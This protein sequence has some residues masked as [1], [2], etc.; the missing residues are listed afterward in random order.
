MFC[1]RYVEEEEYENN[2]QYEKYLVKKYIKPLVDIFEVRYD[3]Q[4]IDGLRSTSVFKP[5]E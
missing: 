1:F 3:W 4:R 2:L 5:S